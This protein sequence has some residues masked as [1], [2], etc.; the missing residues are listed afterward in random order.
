MTAKILTCSIL[1]C[2][3][4]LAGCSTTNST[5]NTRFG[6]CAAIGGAV[7]GIPGAIHGIATGG[8]SL[9]AG[10]LISGIACARSDKIINHEFLPAP[11]IEGTTVA[12]FKINS[13]SLDIKSKNALASFLE[14]KMDSS[15]TITGH[16]CDL[17][18]KD[19]N[20][21]LSERRAQ[22][23]MKYL[24]EK[25]VSSQNIKTKGYRESKPLYPNTS[26]K[27]RKMNRRV[28]IIVAE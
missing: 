26:N 8:V 9:A 24:L 1:I 10:A 14:G 21:G 12:R 18:S 27:N 25:G 28:E 13:S 22:S 17:G 2:S 11:G 20:Q 16:T 23:V 3:V 4:L 7:W 19:F 6:K 5:K 15:F